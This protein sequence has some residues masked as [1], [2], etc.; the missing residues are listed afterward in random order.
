MRIVRKV[1]VFWFW[2]TLVLSPA[3]LIAQEESY[4]LPGD[5]KQ[6]WQ[7]FYTKG[8]IKCHAVWGEGERIGPD[9]SQAPAGQH[10]TAAGLIAEMWN[11]GPEMWG[12][13]TTKGAEHKQITQGEMADIFAFLYFIRYTDEPG[14]PPKGKEL[15]TAKKCAECHGIAGKGGKIGPDL[16]KWSMYT[17][18]IVWAQM[19]WNHATKMK[20]EM[21]KKGIP[22]PEF[23]GNEMVDLIAYIRSIKPAAEKVYLSPG[24]PAEGKTLFSQKGCIKCHAIR[25]K[26]GK[27]G[28]DLGEK[29]EFPPT[30]SQLAGRMWN[31]FPGM[32]EEMEKEKVSIPELSAKDMVSITAYLFSVRYFDPPGD[33]ERGERVFTERKC[34]HCHTV[35]GRAKETIGPDLSGLRGKVSPILLATALWNHGPDMFKR[36][37][38]EN[39]RWE[40]A[41]TQ[42]VV[43]IMEYLNNP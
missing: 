23:K 20:A 14:D 9:L 13:I 31:H 8:C 22:W 28:P 29:K 7:T 39:I 24:D 3:L 6:G 21:G 36:M 30:L 15:L 25:G 40:R 43:D 1:L 41:T 38:E 27:K 18:P 16:T 17:N 33:K 42:E 35:G 11:H 34:S 19:M 26:G 2:A 32:W 12:K 5:A 10:M 37:K 4:I